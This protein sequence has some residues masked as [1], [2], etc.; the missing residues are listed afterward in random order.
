MNQFMRMAIE[1]SRKNLSSGEGGPFGVVIVRNGEVIARAHNE[2]LKTNDPSMHAEINAIRIATQRLNTFDL[3]DCE[4]Y[5][6]CEPCPMCL[7]AMIWAKIP[8][9]C[10]GN[11]RKDA[12][13]IGFDDDVIYQYLTGNESACH[14]SGQQC[15]ADEAKQV[16][17]EWSK[18]ER[19]MY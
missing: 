7:A 18:D 2:V 14:I 8:R 10:Y 11:T 5:T 1:E 13:G 17:V 9:Y 15:D 4:L 19:Q 3:S 6:S 12:A 16:F